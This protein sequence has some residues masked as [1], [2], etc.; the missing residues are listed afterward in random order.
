MTSAILWIAYSGYLLVRGS[1]DDD[2]RRA[3]LG[4]VLAIVGMADV[5]LVIMATRWFRGIHPVAPTMEPSMRMVLLL[6]VLGF[7]AF[8]CLLLVL[9]RS[10][11]HLGRQLGELQQQTDVG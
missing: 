7:S 3:R 6:S 11:I 10:Q 1:L 9:R 4:T 5:P 8:F 2:H